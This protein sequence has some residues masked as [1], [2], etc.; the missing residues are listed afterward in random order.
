MVFVLSHKRFRG[1]ELSYDK[2]E[3][4]E[5]LLFMVAAGFVPFDVFVK[6]PVPCQPVHQNSSHSR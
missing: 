6:K 4:L 1:A 5:I 2:L 3:Q